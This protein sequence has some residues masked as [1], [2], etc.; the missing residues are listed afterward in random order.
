MS[1]SAESLLGYKPEELLDHSMEEFLTSESALI[2]HNTINEIISS[3]NA[4]IKY[5]KNPVFQLEQRC[6]DNLLIWTEVAI[7]VIYDETDNPKEILG[8]TRDIT[9]RKRLEAAERDQRNISENQ[10]TEL[11]E[12]EN[13]LRMINT[14]TTAA[15]GEVDYY[16]LIQIIADKLGPL[17]GADG[18][19]ITLLDRETGRILPGAAYGP[20]K[21]QYR[22]LRQINDE[23][24]LTE[25]VLKT[26]EAVIIKD[27]YDSTQNITNINSFYANRSILSLPL[28]ANDLKLG[29]VIISFD[30]VHSFLD[31]EIIRFEQAAR[32]IALAIAKA[33]ALEVSHNRAREAETLQQAGATVAAT[34]NQSEAIDRLL[35]QLNNV[36]PYDSASVQLIE[37]DVLRIVGIRGFSDPSVVVGL[38]FPVDGE[39]PS[40]LVFETRKPFI[41]EDAPISYPVFN[42]PPYHKIHGWMG[43]P[44]IFQDRLIGV[45]TLFSEKPGTFSQHHA[46]LAV[47]F[48]DQVSIALENTRLYQ[49]ALVNAQQSETL[50]RDIQ[51][52][53]ASSL[54][55]N[56]V[57]QAIYRAANR[58]M[59]TD[60]FEI[61]I[62]LDK[63]KQINQILLSNNEKLSRQYTKLIESSLLEL[64]LNNKTSMIIDDIEIWKNLNPNYRNLQIHDN[65]R[66][67]IAVPMQIGERI[68]GIMSSQS[69]KP[70]TFTSVHREMLELLAAPAA[71]ALE[72]SHLY[73]EVHR[74]AITD[75]LTGL[76][77]RRH[78]FHLARI[79]YER[80]SRFDRSISVIMLDIDR[81]KLVNDTYGHV[82]GDQVLRTV[83]SICTD[84][85]RS[86]D[87]IGRYGG[88]EFIIL[89]PETESQFAKQAAERLLNQ[90]TSTATKT[91]QGEIF[92]TVSMGLHSLKVMER[93]GISPEAIL[94]ELIDRADQ[95]LY[96]AKQNG[97]NRVWVW[98]NSQSK[99]E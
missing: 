59:S 98:N 10:A 84:T 4:D 9:T 15:L 49:E 80:A 97:R 87:L 45:I 48:A 67:I 63:E 35:E 36:V 95:A 81:F 37:D 25:M 60:I 23:L 93:E 3:I 46:R 44:L 39:N 96:S 6:K 31:E 58:V 43:I 76:Y 41:L 34:L 51:E 2:I 14:I 72:N 47:A 52:I 79:E 12:R 62:L 55:S 40:A 53:S 94:Q 74:L 11:Q 8:V 1:P 71:V 7:S 26:K 57:Y 22:E 17:M 66:S 88:E 82:V 18:C 30:E 61:S 42:Q 29:A 19:Y 64:V 28:I 73:A 83:A 13:F 33:Q 90:F 38:R 21:D 70:F 56:E 78:F 20:M 99:R 75:P 69:Y 32:Q 65:I 68:F 27:I 89:L 24:A 85:M 86:F 54:D 5:S 77:N 16:E 91:D 92:I 50:R